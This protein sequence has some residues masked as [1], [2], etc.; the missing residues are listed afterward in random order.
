M[1]TKVMRRSVVV[2]PSGNPHR[3]LDERVCTARAILDRAGSRSDQNV[4]LCVSRYRRS[5][6]LKIEYQLRAIGP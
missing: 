5:F 1:A 6:H 2:A 3:A 4:C